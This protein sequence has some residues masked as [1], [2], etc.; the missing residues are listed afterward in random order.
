MVEQ[1]VAPAPRQGRIAVGHDHGRQARVFDVG[2]READ[3]HAGAE[4]ALGLHRPAARLQLA[5]RR[6]VA[7]L[8]HHV[9]QHRPAAP[10]HGR[11]RPARQQVEQGPA[12]AQ[13]GL[14]HVDVRIGLVAGDHGRVAGAA[15]VQ[16]GV[17]V[18]GDADR[19]ARARW[20]GSG[21][22]ARLR[23]PRATSVTIAP[24]RSSR[25]P[26]QP[27]ATAAQ[28]LSGDVLEGGVVDRAARPG[29]GGDR[30]HDLGAR[31]ASASSMKAA[32]AEPVPW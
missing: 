24:C 13:P 10:G 9:R 15:V 32:I 21:A 7:A 6:I 5:V 14:V 12:G 27:A 22:A 26:S 30:D 20:R 29:A 18:E 23:R 11:A 31:R 17:H 8:A 4:R 19:H 28:M 2:V 25:T 3:E 16:V 1:L